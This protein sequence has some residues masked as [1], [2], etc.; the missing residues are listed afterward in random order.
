MEQ[1]ATAFEPGLLLG[2][3][4]LVLQELLD[5]LGRF[6]KKLL[7]CTCKGVRTAMLHYAAKI[8]FSLADD[9]S[10]GSDSQANKALAALLATR[11]E[12]LHLVL[13]S[14][15]CKSKTNNP[16]RVL[17]QLATQQYPDSSGHGCVREL[18]L[19]LHGETVS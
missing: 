7:L 18:S 6:E 4:P 16:M 19:M 3:P 9:S 8:T 17:G 2:L 11:T 10:D 1:P 12:P 5:Q 13:E 14:E 15:N